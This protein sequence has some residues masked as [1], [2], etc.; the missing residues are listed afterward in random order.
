MTPMFADALPS[1]RFQFFLPFAAICAIC[2]QGMV[3]D[4]F[5]CGRRKWPRKGTKSHKETLVSSRAFLWLP[6]F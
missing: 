5:H 4:L 1:S 3:P 2:G 6:T